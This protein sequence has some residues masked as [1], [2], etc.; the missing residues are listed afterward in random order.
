[1][2][3]RRWPCSALLVLRLEPADAGREESELSEAV[4]GNPPRAMAAPCAASSE[5]GGNDAA[6][7]DDGTINGG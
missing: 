7:G 6:F 1:M 5:G 3:D 4:R 2:N